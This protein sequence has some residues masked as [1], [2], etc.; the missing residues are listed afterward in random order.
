MK[1]FLETVGFLFAIAGAAGIVHHFFGWFRLWTF[2]RHLTFLGDF[3]LWVNPI[4]LV[5]GVVLMIAADGVHQ[6]R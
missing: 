3:Q 6:R 2:T 1:K 5:L 4:L